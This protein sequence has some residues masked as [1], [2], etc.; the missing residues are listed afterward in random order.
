MHLLGALD[1]PSSGQALFDGIDLAKMS[2]GQRSLLRRTKIDFGFAPSS[3]LRTRF[4]DQGPPWN[5]QATFLARRQFPCYVET[6][7]HGH[8]P[9]KTR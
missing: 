9:S 4:P 8:P 1:T 2:D 3:R 6:C 7:M 5:C